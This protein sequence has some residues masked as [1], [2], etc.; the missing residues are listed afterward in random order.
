MEG[1]VRGDAADDSAYH[2]GVA[3]SWSHNASAD[4]WTFQLRPDAVWSDGAPLTSA[5]FEFAYHRLLHPHFGGRYA[6]MLY[7][8]KGAE[9]YNKN[10]R[11]LILCSG[12]ETLPAVATPEVLEAVNWSGDENVQ[13][14]DD[15]ARIKRQG[16]D[17]LTVEDWQ[18]LAQNPE[19]IEWPEELTADQRSVLIERMLADAEA[20]KPDL[21]ERAQ[22]G[23]S[24]PDAQTVVLR[25][26]SPMPQLP[27][28]LLHYT[29]FPVPAHSIKQHGGMLDRTGAWTR[30]GRA[31]GNGPFVMA[32]HRFNQMVEVRKNPLYHGAQGVALKAI[33][34][35]P[36]VNGFTET[37]M[38]F[39]GKLHVTNNVPPEMISY[40]QKKGG[41]EYRTENYY[42]TIFYRLNTTKPPLND[43]RV[44]RA[45]S[46]AM[47]RASIVRDVACGAGMPCQGFTPPGA[48]YASV[49]GVDFQPEL[50]RRL[51][52]EAGYP[53]GQ[54]FP[55]LELMTT[56]REVQKSM[57]EVIQAM[58]KKHLGIQVDI[59]SC[60]WTAY[61]YAQNSMQF[62]ICSSS[63]SGDYLDP[64]TF[65]DLWRAGA[66]NNNTGWASKEYER[67]LDGAYKE[68]SME[69][70]LKGMQEAEK[71]M[72]KSAPIIPIYWARRSYLKRPEV[73]GW[74][75]LLLDNHIPEAVHLGEPEACEDDSC[76]RK[77]EESFR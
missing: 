38:Y 68:G 21:W 10:R 42:A 19:L 11:G 46:L 44:R 51:L 52:A 41:S 18:K 64:A 53:G 45:L 63:W 22:V 15:V 29:W 23:I 61:K 9:D 56:S 47:D 48:G 69:G 36:I 5:D 30:P 32:E 27:L 71:L 60:E 77:E 12:S 26:R 50:A 33:Q 76:L 20:G 74:S 31:V 55:K 66:G 16:L 37:R 14:E 62:D 34:F 17:K 58:W 75:P 4:E 70:R 72:L 1:L 35:L 73:K 40:A 8:L 13:G 65:L 39:D 25:L 24:C 2:P 59:R 54:G 67:I 6:D 43:P 28:L 57:A 7:P 49:G 3:V